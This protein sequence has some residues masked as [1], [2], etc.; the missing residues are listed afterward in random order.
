M[1]QATGSPGDPDGGR[2]D[3]GW[4]VWAWGRGAAVCWG[5]GSQEVRT[6]VGVGKEAGWR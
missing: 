2:G 3:D 1:E 6:G 4:F 5:V